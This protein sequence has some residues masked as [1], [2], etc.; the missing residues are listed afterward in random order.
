[1]IKEDLFPLLMGHFNSLPFETR[2]VTNP[3]KFA[4]CMSL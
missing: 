4:R 3:S 2:K 1:V